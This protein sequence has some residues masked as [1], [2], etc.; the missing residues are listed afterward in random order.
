MALDGRLHLAPVN[1]PHRV[2][3][4]GTG[5]GEIASPMPVVVLRIYGLVNMGNST[6]IWAIDFAE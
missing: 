6:G 4:V 5:T 3:D 1:N 2:L